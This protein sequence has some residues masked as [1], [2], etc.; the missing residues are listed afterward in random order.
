MATTLRNE[1]T[2]SR[3]SQWHNPRCRRSARVV[4][5]KQVVGRTPVFV[6]QSRIHRMHI[7]RVRR[8]NHHPDSLPGSRVSREPPHVCV[9]KEGQERVIVHV[10]L[11]EANGGAQTAKC[12][13]KRERRAIFRPRARKGG[14]S[15]RGS[16][17]L[18]ARKFQP[19]ETRHRTFNKTRRASSPPPL[20]SSL[21]TTTPAAIAPLK[22]AV[23]L[24]ISI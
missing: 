7:F 4:E 11:R 23:A 17:A 21:S 1:L 12:R 9:M 5:G 10:N 2:G 3:A 6:D 14:P 18:F 20:S 15:A 16:G 19:W 13:R 8:R 22:L 24:R